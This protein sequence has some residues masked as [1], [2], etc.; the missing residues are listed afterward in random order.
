M[1]EKS[2]IN[3]LEV[4]NIPRNTSIQKEPIMQGELTGYASIDKPWLKYYS[5]ESIEAKIPEMTAYE[6]MCNENQDNLDTI[7]IEYYGTKINFKDYI[8]EIDKVSESFYDLGIRE[9]DVVTIISIT[10]PELE[11]TFYALNKIGAI[12]NL[13]DVRSDSV[14][15]NKYLNDVNSKVVISLDIFLPVVDKAIQNT[16]VTDIITISPFNSVPRLKRFLANVNDKIKNKEKRKLIDNIKNKDKYIEWNKFIKMYGCKILPVSYKK[17]QIAA[18]VHTGGTTGVSK[19][20]KIS[21]YNFNAL[22]FQYK[23][24][25]TGYDKGDTFL[26]DIVPFVAYG[27][28]TTIHMPTCL[29]ITNIIAPILSP[30]EFTE[31]M[32]KYKPNH[33]ATVPS[34]LDDFMSNEKTQNFDWSNLKHIGIGGDKFSKEKEI[35]LKKFLEEHNSNASLDKGYGMS[36]LCSTAT[37]CMGEVNKLTSLGIPLPKTCVGIFEENSEKELKYGEVGEICISG[38]TIMQGYLNNSEEENKIIKIHTDGTK[39]VHSGDLGTLDEDGFLF[40]I[41][42]IK[43]MIIH[44]GFKLY[45]VKIEETI[46]KNKNVDCCCVIGIPSKEFGSNAEAHIVLKKDSIEDLKQV[47]EELIQLCASELP[48]Y[49]QPSEYIFRERLPLTTVGKV[50]YKSVEKQRILQLKKD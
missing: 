34:Y 45:P 11:K 39:W 1:E 7:A 36:E 47:R 46:M 48:K 44:G 9:G 22:A 37:S 30:K 35:A 20:V 3:N 13:V 17:N 41:G 10:T 5:K 2:K 27:I 23:L 14:A 38:P 42:R 49:S 29:G 8:N 19:T 21:N 40:L 28:V 33:T 43:R 24:L 26:N 6:Y 25:N 4:N 31:F 15:L 32:V 50:D 12:M 18:F 16:N